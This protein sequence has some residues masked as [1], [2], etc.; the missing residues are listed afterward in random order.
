[1]THL[2]TLIA[3]RDHI[4]Q[5]LLEIAK[6]NTSVAGGKPNSTGGP[7]ADHETRYKALRAR[8]IELRRE[9]AAEEGGFTIFTEA[10]T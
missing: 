6:G 7:G 1:M 9:I 3:E 10:D 2:E 8:S 5:Q 4:A